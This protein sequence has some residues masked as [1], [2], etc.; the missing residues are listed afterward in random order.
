MV[1][2]NSSKSCFAFALMGESH[3]PSAIWPKVVVISQAAY[4]FD[5][6]QQSRPPDGS[7]ATG[8][9][10]AVLEKAGSYWLV[11]SEHGD[12]GF[13][14]ADHLKEI[15]RGQDEPKSEQ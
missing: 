5:G 3:L 7:L 12:R 1:A 2:L 15:D 11:L 13:V 8:T 9:E 4:Y 10:V 6:P 14:A